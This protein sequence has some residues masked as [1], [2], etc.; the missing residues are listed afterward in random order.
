MN[1][2]WKHYLF[3]KDTSQFRARPE[4]PTASS[5]LRVNGLSFLAIKD[6]SCFPSRGKEE[7]TPIVLGAFMFLGGKSLWPNGGRKPP[8]EL[9]IW[10]AWTRESMRTVDL[11]CTGKGGK[12]VSW[13]KG[14]CFRPWTIP[15]LG[16]G[17]Q[18]CRLVILD[19]VRLKNQDAESLCF[20]LK[21]KKD[22]SVVKKSGPSA[23]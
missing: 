2:S 9:S 18:G 16:A 23:L 21:E 7:S 19:S 8:W 5:G 3:A 11:G 1:C 13:H 14:E 6:I 22:I 4:E 10:R 17:P 20:H 12:V 15:V